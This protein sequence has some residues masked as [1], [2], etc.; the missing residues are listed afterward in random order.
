MYLGHLH[1]NFYCKAGIIST[2]LDRI[3]CGKTFVFEDRH[4]SLLCR[5]EI[6]I[7]PGFSYQTSED[8]DRRFEG[9][10]P[11]DFYFHLG[12]CVQQ[13]ERVSICSLQ[14]LPSLNSVLA[15]W[16]RMRSKNTPWRPQ[17]NTMGRVQEN[18]ISCSFSLQQKT[19]Q[20]CTLALC[21]H[22][23]LGIHGTCC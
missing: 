8:V 18:H 4:I 16:S 19:K 21:L 6:L 15:G 22:S 13:F 20:K 23:H 9:V 14:Y 11:A 3:L 10:S 12:K 2:A 17:L 5:K 7:C 1:N